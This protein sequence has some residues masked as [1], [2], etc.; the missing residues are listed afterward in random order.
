M[1][2]EPRLGD[3][4]EITSYVKDQRDRVAQVVY[5]GPETYNPK[6][7]DPKLFLDK[8]VVQEIGE[9]LSV[10]RFRPDNYKEM[11]RYYKDA[12][13][14]GFNKVKPMKP[15]YRFGP[16]IVKSTRSHKL[17]GKPCKPRFFS[18]SKKEMRTIRIPRIRLLLEGA[19]AD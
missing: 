16:Y 1:A 4:V 8:E 3:W 18:L 12:Q 11:A 17:T 15:V 14:R 10:V 7:V 5:I 19:D 9:A 2:F 6:E 13:R